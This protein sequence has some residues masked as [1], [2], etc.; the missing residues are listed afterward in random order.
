[1]F[2]VCGAF[3][4]RKDGAKLSLDQKELS[5]QE[6]GLCSGVIISDRFA[7]TAAH[8]VEEGASR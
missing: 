4:K 1:M 7:L 3:R 6:E 5:E 2:L 8:C